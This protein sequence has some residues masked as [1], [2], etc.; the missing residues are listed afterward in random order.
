M[1]IK[2]YA[3]IGTGA[4]GG[5]YGALLQRYGHEVHFLL[6]RD[7]D[8]VKKTGLRIDSVRG[9]FTLPTVHAHCT[10]ATIPPCDVVLVTLKTTQ[11]YLLGA[12]LPPVLKKESVV[13]IM[14]NGLGVEETVA[15]IPSVN[16]VAGALCFICSNRQGPGHIRHLDYGQVIL[17]EHS[18]KQ[19][20]A[21]MTASLKSIATDFEAAGISVHC[22]ENLA[23]ARWKKLVWNI[24]F[25]GLSVVLNATTADLM[26]NKHSRKLVVRLMNE[27][28][29]GAAACGQSIDENFLT[30]MITATETMAPYRTSMKIDYDERRPMELEAIYG[31]PLQRV[32]SF[33]KQLPAI[34][35]LYEALQFLNERNIK[36]I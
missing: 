36:E 19:T 7:Y 2:R 28:M 35:M 27:V 5:Y 3:V 31:F 16:C 22:A 34:R 33:G 11:N 30:E 17:G 4:V 8:Q 13:V 21:G 14:Q 12:M 29:E 15:A 18:R 9:D 6:N 25:N 24:P 23:E 20:G 26:R 1:K 32:Q 10:I